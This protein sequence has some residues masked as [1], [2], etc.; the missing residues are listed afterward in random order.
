ML[1]R[2]ILYIA[3]ALVPGIA[4]AQDRACRLP[5]PS[6][7]IEPHLL[8]VTASPAPML[9]FDRLPG[10]PGEA[11]LCGDVGFEVTTSQV[12]GLFAQ[13]EFT[14]VTFVMPSDPYLL[15][16][17]IG[18]LPNAA[19]R[20]ATDDTQTDWA[21][22]W[23]PP[24]GSYPPQR[25]TIEAAA[26]GALHLLAVASNSKKT[27]GGVARRTYRED[28]VDRILQPDGN[29]IA[30]EQS[31]AEIAPPHQG[32]WSGCAIRLWRAGDYMIVSDNPYCGAPDAY[33]SGM[34]RRE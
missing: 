21:G 10:C 23:V 11:S 19:L 16:Y 18:W 12:I 9:Q 13:G 33:L 34:Y 6:Q 30:F 4:A 2:I 15:P 20:A 25:I 5:D 1:S 31:E 17:R 32:R 26:D 27:E 14:C 8:D 29:S 22:N 3:L 28:V 7:S 24:E